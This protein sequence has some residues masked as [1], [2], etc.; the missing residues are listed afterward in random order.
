M[1]FSHQSLWVILWS[2][3]K[4]GV[5][6]DHSLTGL[7]YR[8]RLFARDSALSRL[9]WR[10]LPD[11]TT[12]RNNQNASPIFW[13]MITNSSSTPVLWKLVLHAMSTFHFPAQPCSHTLP[14]AVLNRF[15]GKPS[16]SPPRSPR[17][18]A[19][20]FLNLI[21]DAFLLHY[22][23]HGSQIYEQFYFLSALALCWRILAFTWTTAA[24]M[25]KS[26]MSLFKSWST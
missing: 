2:L 20:L 8:P 15:D 25:T 18:N 6:R 14:T 10:H 3:L 19:S 24:G 16:L 11:L 1:F 7:Q 4:S 23:T 22:S 13:R 21:I 5:I 9:A 26:M 12:H 17:V